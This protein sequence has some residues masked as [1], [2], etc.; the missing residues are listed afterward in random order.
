MS[1]RACIHGAAENALWDAINRY[2]MSC[3]GDPS[4]H[5]HGNTLRQQAVVEV[6]EAVSEIVRAC[7]ADV[8][9]FSALL[10]EAEAASAYYQTTGQKVGRPPRMSPA[11]VKLILDARANFGVKHTH[12]PRWHEI[13]TEG[14]PPDETMCWV[15][16]RHGSV[17]VAIADKHRAGGWTNEDTWEDFD[18]EVTHWQPAVAPAPPTREPR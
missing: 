15:A 4:D 7:D 13:A 18:G 6:S 2:A 16:T 11:T 17:F 12:E 9:A 3:G 8:S 5:V 14:L 1:E 10:G